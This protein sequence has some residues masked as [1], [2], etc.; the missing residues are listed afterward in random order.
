MYVKIRADI[1]NTALHAMANSNGEQL[2]HRTSYPDWE[3]DWLTYERL[4]KE[5]PAIDDQ[6]FDM[7]AR[8]E[9]E[10]N[11]SPIHD[12]FS[13]NPPGT[14]MRLRELVGPDATEDLWDLNAT[15]A[16]EEALGVVLQ[17]FLEE[18]EKLQDEWN[19]LTYT[20]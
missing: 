10:G 19:R 14:W 16:S 17:R 7:T 2:R 1:L 11:Y 18:L 12:F 20:P 15:L 4:A 3:S 5:I 13:I 8:W 6:L 9:E